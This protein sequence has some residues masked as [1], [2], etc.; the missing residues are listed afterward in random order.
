MTRQKPRYEARAQFADLGRDPTSKAAVAAMNKDL[1]RHERKLE[2]AAAL[3]ERNELV[4]ETAR[5]LKKTNPPLSKNSIA[6]E[7]EKILSEDY[8]LGHSQ[9]LKIM[10]A[11]E[12]ALDNPRYVS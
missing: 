12:K 4:V 7:I 5:E 9:I 10:R 2:L 6:V 11:G 1:A 8:P 3:K